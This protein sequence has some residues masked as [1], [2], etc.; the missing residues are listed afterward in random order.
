MVKKLRLIIPVFLYS[1]VFLFFFRNPVTG[2][3]VWYCCDNLLINI[4]A[5]VFETRQLLDTGRIPLWNPYIFSGTPFLADINLSP[6]YPGFIPFFFLDPFRALS[7]VILIHLWLAGIGAYLLLRTFGVSRSG[8]LFAAVTFGFSGTL[9]SYTNNLPMMQVVGLLP[10]VVL[11][12]IRFINN[13]NVSNQIAVILISSLQ[14]LAGHPQLVYYTWIFV[15]SYLFTVPRIPV[16]AKLSLLTRI[17]LPVISLCAV[18]LIPAGELALLSDRVRQ[19]WDYAVFGSYNP[20]WLAKLLLP[21]LMGN[22]QDGTVWI[23]LGSLMGYMGILPV[24]LMMTGYRRSRNTVFLGIWVILSLVLSFGKFTPLYA[25]YYQ[26]IPGAAFFRVPAHF[27][28]I[29]AL[30]VSLLAGFA[31]DAFFS[32]QTGPKWLLITGL[33][34]ILSGFVLYV[35]RAGISVKFLI[36][37]SAYGARGAQKAEILGQAGTI[38]L[39]TDIAV[40][41]GLIAL[42]CLLI[43]VLSGI[44]RRNRILTAG[45]IIL[46]AIADFQLYSTRNVI[47]IPTGQIRSYSSAVSVSQAGDYPNPA[48]RIYTGPD[49]YTADPEF[50]IGLNAD[51]REAYWQMRILRPDYNILFPYYSAD[52]YASLAP[53]ATI[54]YLERNFPTAAYPGNEYRS[55][56]L[57]LSAVGYILDIAG[58]NITG[59]RQDP[60][61]GGSDIALYRSFVMPSQLTLI[62]PDSSIPV[63][64]AAYAA[65]FLSTDLSA[66]VASTLVYSDTFYPGWSARIDGNQVPVTEYA[67]V[68]KSVPISPGYHTVEFSFEPESVIAGLTLTIFG[69]IYLIILGVGRVH[70]AGIRNQGINAAVINRTRLANTPRY[71]TIISRRN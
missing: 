26:F 41:F 1:L 24:L 32:R 62:S 45:L 22:Q 53:A 7:V 21:S 25:L 43:T 58:R 50:G 61:S 39:V 55:E 20:I 47:T 51:L 65:G 28:L 40:N 37:L 4:P 2:G 8:S 35:F 31:L 19:G 49:A 30:S 54:K 3:E 34:A 60:I 46:A 16:P 48:V 13:S 64:A 12:W 23:Q 59:F 70:P 33:A 63:Q 15:I 56:A 71:P 52:G 67:G 5:R 66:T 38:R 42:Y 17:I 44:A 6:L 18:Q 69:G 36:F 29:T 11:G 14:V 9:I 10:W 57:R 68:Y 27:L